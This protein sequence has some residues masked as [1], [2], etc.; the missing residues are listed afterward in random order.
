MNETTAD[1]IEDKPFIPYVKEED[2]P[3]LLQPIIGPY[4]ERMGFLPNA[5]KLYMHRPEIAETLFTLNSRVMRHPSSKLDQNL[6][7]R[8]GAV[9]SKT[10]GCTYCTAHHCNILLASKDSGAEGWEM[11]EEELRGMLTGEVE[12]KGEFEKACF[13]FVRAASADPSNVP[14]EIRQRLKEHL[15]P[16]Q[17]IELACVVGFWKFFNT[18]HESLK[19]PVESHLH[20]YT[21]Y[22]TL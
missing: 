13:D 12:P 15:N 9:A 14:D 18:V 21:E 1:I 6:K 8:L 20:D 17:I 7:R 5:L 10:N 4:I 22:V 19:V 16:E 11:P 2:Y 3:E